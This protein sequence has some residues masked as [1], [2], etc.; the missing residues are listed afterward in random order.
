MSFFRFQKFT[1]HQD[2]CAMK[3]GSDAVAFGASIRC[4]DSFERVLDIGTGTG[5]L[6][7]MLAQRFPKTAITALEIVP[8]AAL[9]AQENVANSQF[10]AQITVI[11]TALQ[12]FKTEQKFHRIISNPPFFVAE[13]SMLSPDE[14]RRKARSTLTLSYDDLLAYA[15]NNLLDWGYFDVLLPVFESIDFIEK[16]K[17]H[18]FFLAKKTF[19][20]DSEST[21][22]QQK[23]LKRVF[24]L[25]IYTGTKTPNSK[26]NDVETDVENYLAN[27]EIFYSENVLI[28]KDADKKYTLAYKELIKDFYFL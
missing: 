25:F 4:V 5:I 8:E 13:K 17:L 16:A 23:A 24:L 19:L 14:N 9:Q 22:Q 1:I 27:N 7:L 11:N 6:A 21:N 28:L 12:D 18:H 10:S 20:Q 15:S 26:E 3:L 2:R